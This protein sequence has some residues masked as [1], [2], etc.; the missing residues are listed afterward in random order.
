MANKKVILMILDG[1]G[2][3]QNPEVSAPFN[4]KTPFIESLERDDPHASLLVHK[5]H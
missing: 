1:W 5:M 2:I 3:T 4:A